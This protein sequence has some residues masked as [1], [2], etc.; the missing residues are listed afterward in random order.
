MANPQRENGHLDVANDIVEYLAKTQLSGY[1][2]RVLWALWRKTWCWVEKDKNGK[3]KKDKNGEILKKKKEQISSKEWE[4]LTGLNK[5]NISRTLRELELRQIVIKFDNKNKWGFQKDYNK[6]LPPIRKIVIKNDN[7]YF[8]IKN[9][10]VFIKND[11]GI[12]KIDNKKIPKDLFRK[13]HRASKETLKET[14]KETTTHNEST[15]QELPKNTK[16]NIDKLIQIYKETYPE[17][18]RVYKLGSI[19]KMRDLISLAISE[20]ISREAIE[21]RIKEVKTGTPWDIITD[22]WIDEEK[23][24]EKSYEK[25]RKLYGGE[26]G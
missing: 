1:E 6:W 15:S 21:E 24:E 4:K 13:E 19:V 26:E 25:L 23:K 5:Y 12:S 17:H 14:L 20:G 8:V 18:I 9:D 3:V 16:E 7:T 11:N 22:K 10:N 2:S